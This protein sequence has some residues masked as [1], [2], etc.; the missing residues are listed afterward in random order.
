MAGLRTILL[1]LAVLLASAA[2]ALDRSDVSIETQG[3]AYVIH[4]AFDVPANVYQVRSVL[5]DYRNPD[6][7]TSMVRGREIIS[8]QD[9]LIRVSRPGCR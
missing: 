8:Q 9:G 6:R 7:L 4:M 3:R 2:L 1:L 5:T